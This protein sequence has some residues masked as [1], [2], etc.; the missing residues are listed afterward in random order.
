MGQI[1]KLRLFLILGLLLL[2][3]VFVHAEREVREVTR[4]VPLSLAMGTLGPW[5]PAGD[6][7]LDSR[8]VDALDLDDYLFRNFTN[9]SETVNLYI[10]YYFTS[11]K[12][13][14]AH[15]PLVCMPGQGWT[16]SGRTESRSN[17]QIEGKP[18][19]Y[20]TMV[21]ELDGRK[22]LFIYWFQAY[23]RTTPNTL[24][25]KLALW[26]QSLLGG[27]EDNAFVRVG[28]P[29]NG[30]TVEEGMAVGLDFIENLYPE[31][32]GY[33][34]TTALLGLSP[35][36]QTIGLYLLFVSHA[37]YFEALFWVSILLLFYIYVGY[38]LLVRLLGM[39]RPREVQ[40]SADHEPAVTILIAAFNEA[41]SIGQTVRN[42]LELDYPCEKLEIIVVS[43]CSEDGTDAI[44]RSFPETNV[45]LIR[46][47]QRG[48]KTA[49]LNAAVP[50][51]KG[52]ILV[53]SDANSLYAPDALKKLT[54]NFS[55][56][57]VGYVT[58]Q[59]VY[60][61]PGQSGNGEGCG[62][63]MRYE[64][65]LRTLETKIG[66]VV[67]VD[68]GI[69]A[70][71][72]SLFR[73]MNPD[74][75]PDFVLPLKVV[76]QGYRVVYEPEA[77]LQEPA[78][79]K[80]ADEYRMRVRVTLRALWALFDM[81]RLL[82]FPKNPLFSLQLWS[83]K[84]LRYFAFV[85]L[86]GAFFSNWAMIGDSFFYQMTF[87]C[88]IGAYLGALISPPLERNGWRFKLLE[89]S[90]YFAVIN[91]AAAHAFGKFLMRKKQVVWTP[92]KG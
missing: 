82:F 20:S 85:F 59:M 6:V 43:D 1:S 3:A 78:L 80:T 79:D 67:G 46:Q 75:L 50:Q 77:I 56:E 23:D 14:A 22:E 57:T 12:V 53:F 90:H 29:L 31:F 24:R 10:G 37:I 9:G 91:M 58:G 42:K 66:S 89:S 25:Q 62:N 52:E 33:V 45:R 47:E 76:E 17:F 27:G 65:T 26:K 70:V 11:Q 63:Y 7:R 44:V 32:L 92:R 8:V 4:D 88:Q 48:G 73:P 34:R 61:N 54:A 84:V 71:R 39:R 19:H 72:K 49:A 69:D 83:H 64:N 36:T 68:G 35:P 81:R 40:K 60:V 51:A 74:Q 30:I 55:D 86:I 87:S 16:V 5:Q 38:P 13:G 28:V 2:T 15:D 41:K 21:A 18:V